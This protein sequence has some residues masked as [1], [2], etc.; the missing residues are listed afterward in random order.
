M[1]LDQL[2]NRH[3]SDKGTRCKST[4]GYTMVYDL[5]FQASRERPLSI[6]EIGLA[7][8]GPEH[9]ASA[10]R[11][12]AGAPSIAMWKAFFPQA[13]IF[14]FDISDFARFQDERFTFVRGD[15]GNRADLEKIAT[16]GPFDIV[17]DDASHA[18]YHQLLTLSVLM[19][20]VKPGGLFVIEDLQWQPKVYE[21]TLP[22]VPKAA[23]L[24][25]DF[26]ANGRVTRDADLLPEGCE[27]ALAEVHTM[28]IWRRSELERMRR[29]RLL[30]EDGEAARPTLRDRW[31]DLRFRLK[32][33]PVKLAILEKRPD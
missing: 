21:A 17:L 14:G 10:D 16:L 25:L 4:H 18:S 19:K 24:L 28:S 12:V 11:E 9:G 23:D 15:A 30:R 13:K 6:L 32:G 7:I 27:A 33:D 31:R 20:A 5:L 3:G 26:R 8:G 2:A 22:K 29:F 1:T